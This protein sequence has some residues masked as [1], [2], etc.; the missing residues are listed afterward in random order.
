MNRA[1]LIDALAKATG[2]TKAQS[3]RWLSCFIETVSENITSE[4]GVKLVGFG[5]F[6]AVYRR[7]RM[8]RNPQTGASIKIPERMVPVFKAGSALKDY[9]GEKT[10]KQKATD[11]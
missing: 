4:E 9:V 2:E 11:G 6:A 10:P 8:G 7:A 1:E 3:E 5:T